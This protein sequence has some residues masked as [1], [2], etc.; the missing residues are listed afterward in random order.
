MTTLSA[1]S[2]FLLL[3]TTIQHASSFQSAQYTS[4]CINQINVHPS[5]QIRTSSSSLNG[6][7][8]GSD[9][10]WAWKE[11]DPTS[12]AAVAS[13]T[14]ATLSPDDI[15][16]QATPFLPAGEFRPKQSLGQNYLRDG[17]TV[18]K[19]VKAFV[20]DATSTLGMNKEEGNDEDV[21]RQT[22]L[23]AVELGPGAGALTDVLLPALGAN[24][25][26]CIEIDQRSVELLTNKHPTLRVQHEDVLQ[27]DYPSL[28]RDEG[29]PLSI[30]G[31]LPY[32][33]TSQIL[34]ALADASH[35][36]AVRSATVTMQWEVGKRI[37][38]PTRTKDYGILSVVFQLYADCNI[39]FKIP[40]TVF[41]PQPKVDSALIGLHFLGPAQLRQRLGGVNPSDLRKVVTSTFQQRRK[42]VRNGLKPLA[43]TVFDG[44]KDKVQE[45]LNGS[46]LPLPQSVLDARDAGDAFALSQELPS[47][48]QKKRPEELTSGQ[49]VELT[50]MLY[51]PKEGE[52]WDEE[53]LLAT[54]VWRK[55]KHG[56]N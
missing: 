44:D 42:T 8:Q 37:V 41:Y 48:W 46:P 9:G 6:W 33:I 45:F 36:D 27:V 47:D 16:A 26:Q 13:S 39:H 11:D 34:F 10:E 20:T 43:A 29:G 2:C 14:T 19:I 1:L 22:D 3:G 51:G 38:A 54:K 12:A 17:N 30:I 23:R 52:D 31:N 53:G 18:A 25:L 40:P 35:T 21:L 28:A 7:V 32:Y 15:S 56:A 5:N 49:F 50:R 55:L 4:S 24:N